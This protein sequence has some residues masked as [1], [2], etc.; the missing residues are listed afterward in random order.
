MPPGEPILFLDEFQYP[1]CLHSASSRPWLRGTCSCTSSRRCASPPASAWWARLLGVCHWSRR[2]NA[3]TALRLAMLQNSNLCT[4]AYD[5]NL[6]LSLRDVHVPSGRRKSLPLLYP[7]LPLSSPDP[8][9]S[10]SHVA[11]VQIFLHYYIAVRKSRATSFCRAALRNLSVLSQR[12]RRGVVDSHTAS[13]VFG[14]GLPA[15]D[16]G[17]IHGSWS[18]RGRQS[19]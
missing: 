1:P 9:H 14:K 18:A 17:W 5:E 12:R 13:A 8:R 3:G 7:L 2:R 15:A 11:T 16:L 10:W 4:L 19:R 6:V